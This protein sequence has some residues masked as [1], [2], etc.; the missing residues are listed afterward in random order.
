[1]L[2]TWVNNTLGT[3][4]AAQPIAPA[5]IAASLYPRLEKKSIN[6]PQNKAPE[7]FATKM[8]LPKI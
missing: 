5:R 3:I 8:M 7:V 1:M 4:K 6:Q 2:S